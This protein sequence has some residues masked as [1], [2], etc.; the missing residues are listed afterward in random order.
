MSVIGSLGSVAQVVL[1]KVEATDMQAIFNNQGN[2]LFLDYYCENK[3]EHNLNRYMAGNTSSTKFNGNTVS[4]FQLAEPTLMW[5]ADW[6]TCK[7]GEVPTVPDPNP[8]AS[9]DW[10]LLFNSPQLAQKAMTGNGKTALYRVSG[11]YVYGHKNP[12]TVNPLL[13]ATF[14]KPP[15]MKDDG[16]LRT[17][18]ASAMAKDIISVPTVMGRI[19]G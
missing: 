9:S 13:L 10:I 3:Y 16:S 15:W 2:G 7:A 1:G 6:T 4:F 11:T 14:P 17:I 5:I 8:P 18:P 12:G 19:K